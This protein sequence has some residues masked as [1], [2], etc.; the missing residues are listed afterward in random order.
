MFTT[1]RLHLRASKPSDEA[2]LLALY[3]DE[4]VAPWIT[5]GYIVPRHANYI[6]TIYAFIHSCVLSCVVEDKA[7]GEFIGLSSF[8]GPMEPKN[9]NA[10][11]CIALLPKHWS[12]GYGFEIMDFLIDY[13][14]ESMNM[15][16]VSLTVF[17]GNE[18]A[19]ALYRRLGFVEEGRHRKIVWLKGAWRDTFYMGILED[20][21]AARKKMKAAIP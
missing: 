1:E 3:N 2:N 17:E 16:R 6:D 19:M 20:E 8:V 5:E 11:I 4:L 21:W 12:K 18:R 9:R 7:T 15:H 14:F 10:V 13:A